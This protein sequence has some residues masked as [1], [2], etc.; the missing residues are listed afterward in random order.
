[1]LRL[2][3]TRTSGDKVFDEVSMNDSRIRTIANDGTNRLVR[4]EGTSSH[5][6]LR[7]VTSTSGAGGSTPTFAFGST[8][9]AGGNSSTPTITFGA[10][11]STPAYAAAGS[12]PAFGA[13]GSTPAFGTPGT[14]L[15]FGAAANGTPANNFFKFPAPSEAAGVAC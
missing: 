2:E 15:S 4:L 1:M 5:Y 12:T 3:L 9:A 8:G 10:A 14:G 7:L 11:G 13:S 6:N